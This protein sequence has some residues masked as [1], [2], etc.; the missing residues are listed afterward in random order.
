MALKIL[1]YISNLSP[2]LSMII[3]FLMI[4]VRTRFETQVCLCQHRQ[5]FFRFQSFYRDFKN[6]PVDLNEINT[7]ISE[8][9]Y[10]CNPKLDLAF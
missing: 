5:N 6:D 3:L 8:E 2:I 10:I 4:Y 7:F 1:K 9:D